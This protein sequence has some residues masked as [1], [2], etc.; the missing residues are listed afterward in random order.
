M[1]LVRVW[2]C[3]HSF[4]DE[5][6]SRAYVLEIRTVSVG[7]DHKDRGGCTYPRLVFFFAAK[8][9]VLAHMNALPCEVIGGGEKLPLEVDGAPR[10]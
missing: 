9:L 7:L 3:I 1:R 6:R 8:V 2:G 10:Y 4:L 5:Y